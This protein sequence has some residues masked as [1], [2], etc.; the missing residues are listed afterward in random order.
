M[1]YARENPPLSGAVAREIGGDAHARHVRT[2]LQQLA[3]ELAGCA[4][5]APALHQE[6]EDSAILVD[7]PPEIVPVPV[8]REEG[9]IQ[10]P[11]IAWLCTPSAQLMGLLLPELETPLAH[12]FVGYDDA[13]F[14]QELFHIAVAEVEAEVEPD[15]VG[16]DFLRKAKPLVRW[17]SSVSCHAI[18][19]A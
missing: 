3:E 4:F 13:T 11:L 5:V 2:A 16:D 6:I 9:F 17:S 12:R 7:C 1:F 14:G 19:I 15:R 8:D 10:M 18:S